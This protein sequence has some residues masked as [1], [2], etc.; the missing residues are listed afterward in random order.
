MT[1]GQD[2]DRGQAHA[3][4]GDNVTEL[5][6]ALNAIMQKGVRLQLAHYKHFEA[7]TG[8]TNVL[9]LVAAASSLT[10]LSREKSL[11]RVY[12][13]EPEPSIVRGMVEQAIN[14]AA[15]TGIRN[16]DPLARHYKELR[17]RA[18]SLGNRKYATARDRWED[19]A[20]YYCTH[21]READENARPIE[22]PSF[23]K[24]RDMHILRPI[25]RELI[26]W[27]EII[28]EDAANDWRYVRIHE[29]IGFSWK[30]RYWWRFL[31]SHYL[32]SILSKAMFIS[33]AHAQSLKLANPVALQKDAVHDLALLLRYTHRSHGPDPIFLDSREE[34]ICSKLHSWFLI[35]EADEKWLNYAL[36]NCQERSRL[37]AS[38]SRQEFLDLVGGD[39]HGRLILQKVASRI[40]SCQCLSPSNDTKHHT[41]ALTE[42]LEME[43]SYRQWLRDDWMKMASGILHQILC[44]DHFSGH[45]DYPWPISRWYE[46]TNQQQLPIPPNPELLGG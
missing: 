18:F 40:G 27:N 32:S 17:M 26:R 21:I 7:L 35:S 24:Y 4:L 38:S 12:N 41:C 19:L 5:A 1:F 8:L 43:R 31:L 11:R 34:M 3:E 45:S 6:R 25:A 23:Y 16:G 20:Y 33:F 9:T 39:P 42:C 13:M 2:S 36:D 37:A 46:G 22:G 44:A 14:R 28:A 29:V 30:E 15:D 10:S